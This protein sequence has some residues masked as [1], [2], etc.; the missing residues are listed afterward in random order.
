MII[1]ILAMIFVFGLLIMGHELG[2][3]LVAKLSG[4]K[5]LEFSFGM[6]PR[7]LKFGK[8][9][10]EYS[11]RA[12][13]IGGFVKMLGEEEQVD[14]PRS[15]S[16]K[17]T[18]ARM[19][20]IVAG[21]LMN[22]LLSVI[23]LAAI[24]MIIGYTKPVINSVAAPPEGETGIVFPA[25]TAGLMPGDRL[26][27]VNGDKILTYEDFKLF[28]Y[29]NGSKPFKLVVERNGDKISRDI[30]PV[31]VKSYDMYM[32]GID[33]VYGQAS[34][35]EGA[36]YGFMSTWT[37]VKQIFDFIGGLFA[38]K[39]STA[40]V[41]GPVGIVKYA[42]DAAR[43]GFGTLLVF[44][45]ILSVNLAIMNLIPFPALDGGWLLILIIE[46][47]RRKKLDANKVG[48]I[49]FVGFAILMV[50]ILLITFK[51]VVNLKIF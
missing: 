36:E 13:P 44:T 28:M 22:I 6:G 42:G 4:V 47:I 9:E 26:Y 19:G 46:G 7:I 3:F 21:P 38:G 48:I 40:D 2:H 15:F 35:I 39:A 5:V 51:D 49:N 14:D 27:S 16:R 50:L 45:A 30:T 8:H 43:Q 34:I 24:S 32:V 41:S 29:Q 17:P 33:P 11:W 18:L 31:Y 23:I 25:K 12:F 20:V 37:Y 10:T 1:T